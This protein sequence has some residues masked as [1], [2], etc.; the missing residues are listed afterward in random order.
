M[1]LSNKITQVK[2][3][4]ALSTKHPRPLEIISTLVIHR[5]AMGETVEVCAKAFTDKS[6]GTGGSMPYHFVIARDGNI[7][8]GVPLGLEAPGALKLN[9]CG[10]QISVFGD[11][12]SKDPTPAQFG[13]LVE[14]CTVLSNMFSS[15]SIVGHSDVPGA[16]GDTGKICPGKKLD[17]KVLRERVSNNLG[18]TVCFDSIQ[19]I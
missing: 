18:K 13:A 10:I 12:R 7:E 15:V 11:F 4:G 17:L 5:Q 6:L 16:A 14:L 19:L 1:K 8:Q 9:K 2:L 3:A